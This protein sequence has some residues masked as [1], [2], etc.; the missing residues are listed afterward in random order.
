VLREKFSPVF[1]KR[2]FRDLT[3]N[4]LRRG[5]FRDLEELNLAVMIG[6]ITSLIRAPEG[7]PALLKRFGWPPKS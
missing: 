3:H 5:I 7:T 4:Q 2:F 6:E 1:R